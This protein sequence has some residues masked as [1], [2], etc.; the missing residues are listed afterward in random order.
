MKLQSRH[1]PGLRCHLKACWGRST[2]TST[3]EGIILCSLIMDMIAH[4]RAVF[5]EK[6]ATGSSSH[7]RGRRTRVFPTV[8]EALSTVTHVICLSIFN[9]LLFSLLVN[10][11]VKSHNWTSF[12]LSLCHYFLLSEWNYWGRYCMNSPNIIKQMYYAKKSLCATFTQPNM[13]PKNP[14]WKM[15]KRFVESLHK[16]R[17]MNAQ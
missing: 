17:S 12:K 10:K 5:S 4:L 14:V 15:G 2:S 1:Q 9:T 6:Q 8:P 13:D 7:S 3:R 11:L 16:R